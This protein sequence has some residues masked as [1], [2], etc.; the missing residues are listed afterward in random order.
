[1]FFKNVITLFYSS[2]PE[3]F[4][5]LLSGRWHPFG[6]RGIN[7]L[8]DFTWQEGSGNPVSVQFKK[9]NAVC[10]Q[11][12]EWPLIQRSRGKIILVRKI[13]DAMPE[14]KWVTPDQFGE[15][16]VLVGKNQPTHFYFLM[17][18]NSCIEPCLGQRRW[19]A[20]SIRDFVKG[21]E[22][23]LSFIDTPIY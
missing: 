4:L 15:L 13:G 17:V 23:D 19:G 9:T 1:M 21:M 16:V 3:C 6:W 14:W 18:K 12:I 11:V 22:D 5:C 20:L 7:S 2:F 8:P 10:L